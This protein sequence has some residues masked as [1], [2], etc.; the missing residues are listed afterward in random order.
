MA[1]MGLHNFNKISNFSDAD[2]AEVMIEPE[3]NNTD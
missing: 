3:V 1:T 2:F